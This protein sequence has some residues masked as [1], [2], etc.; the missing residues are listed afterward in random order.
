MEIY[1]LVLDQ[2]ILINLN[3]G[4]QQNHMHA[5]CHLYKNFYHYLHKLDQSRCK[6]IAVV[7]IP[8]KGLGKTIN[9]R[10]RRAIK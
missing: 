9:D 1:L 8:D 7:E 2:V 5:A 3:D 6:K 4:I 10:L